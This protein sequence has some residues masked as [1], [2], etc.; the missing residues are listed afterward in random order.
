[1]N[2]QRRRERSEGDE[3]TCRIEEKVIS[4]S[5]RENAERRY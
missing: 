5:E 1:M 3:S 2:A 4:L